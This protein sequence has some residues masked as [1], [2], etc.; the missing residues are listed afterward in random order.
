VKSTPVTEQK[1]IG[2]AILSLS[3]YEGDAPAQILQRT[4]K[5]T[6]GIK[7]VDLN[8]AANTLTVYYDLT[9]ITIE[10]V[11]AVIKQPLLACLSKRGRK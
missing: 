5:K 6:S 3:N 1:R 11:R 9:K 7:H 8:Y 10:G 2:R 4:L